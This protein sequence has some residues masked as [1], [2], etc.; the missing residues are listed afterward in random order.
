MFVFGYSDLSPK[1]SLHRKL[2]VSDFARYKKYKCKV[3][4]SHQ[5]EYPRV[6]YSYQDLCIL[7]RPT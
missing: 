6:G 7:V 3:H 5:F 4:K 2:L 1:Y